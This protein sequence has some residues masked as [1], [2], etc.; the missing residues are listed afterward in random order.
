MTNIPSFGGQWTHEKLE[1]LRHYLNAYTTALKRPRFALIY[2]DGFAGAGAYVE[3]SQ[4]YDEF[5]EIHDGSARIALG[6]DDRPFDR[7]LFIEKDSNR[8]QGLRLL[9]DEHPERAIDVVQGD[10]NEEVQKFCR[11]MDRYDRAVVFLDPFATEVSWDTVAAIADTQKIDCWILFPLMA[12]TR[13]MPTGEEPS[14]AWAN[15]LDGIF[16]G[17]E[18]WQGTYADSPQRSLFGEEPQRQRQRG[19]N[20]IADA[21]RRRLVSA[22][23]QVAP[24]RRTFRNSRNV[25]IFDLFFAA[26][27]PRGA[28]IA[29]NIAD[30][31]L[32]N[33]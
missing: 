5:Q 21:Y 14:D 15:R 31:L 20:Q 17:R 22:F 25:E 1:I 33:W 2:V 8:V 16:G 27:N 9:K 28:P 11:A 32:K 30:H 13:L 23:Q 18:F 3:A 7:L 19:S 6:I 10:A 29:I 4:E 24:T 26:G 12:I